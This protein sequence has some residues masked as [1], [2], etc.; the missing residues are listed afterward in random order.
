MVLMLQARRMFRQKGTVPEEALEGNR[1]V[2]PALLRRVLG[3]AG[4]PTLPSKKRKTRPA[5][6]ALE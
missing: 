1:P 4:A 5:D 2:A 6:D 3:G